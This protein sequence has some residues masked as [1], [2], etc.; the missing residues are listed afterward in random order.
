[1]N[2]DMIKQ[3][4]LLLLTVLTAFIRVQAQSKPNIIFIYADDLGYAETGAYGQ[5]KIKTPHLDRLAKEGVRFTQFYTSTPVCAPAR[6]MLLTG[7]HSGHSYIRGNYELGGFPDSLEGGQMPLPEGTVTIG[8]MLQKA[9]YTTAAIGKWGLGM[10]TNT[11][12]PNKQGFNYFYGY[13]DQKQ[14]HNF[15]PSHLW[16]NGQAD[17]LPNP[18]INVHQPLNPATATPADFDGYK[19]KSYA[20]DA[21]TQKA[22]QFIR[23]HQQQP[24]F[25]YLPYT[26]PHVSLQVPD[27]ALQPYL[28]QFAEKPYYG[29]Q[30]Y[31]PHRYPLSAYAAMITYLDT[32][33]GIIMQQVAQLG[34]DKNTIILFSSDNGT[35]FNGGVNAAFFNS[36]GGLKGLKMD[37]YEGGI[38]EP[39]IARWPGKIPAGKTVDIPGVQYDLMATFAAIA[40]VPAPPNDGISLLPAMTGNNRQQA[41]R[42]YLYFEY[43]EKGGAVAIRI[44]KWKA[45]K[46]GLKQNRH[47]PWELY[48]LE[49]DPGEQHNLA[50]AHKDL[51]PQFDRIVQQEHRPAHIR[52]WEFLDPK[53]K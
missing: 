33:V 6:C 47:Q 9:G 17:S 22:T 11:G 46:N 2:A 34:L 41:N 39:L 51:L 27:S 28:G 45:I 10:H 35:T 25:L 4:T 5:Q 7:R 3:T 36:T 19:G 32:Q 44:G 18:Y 1:M 52:E 26:I 8:T 16:E 21:M 53:V 13:L 20:V 12:D 14:S 37:L 49:A 42:N 23:Q 40:G 38:R 43:P 15:Y 50:A 48:D 31:A 24:F 30:G 29:Q